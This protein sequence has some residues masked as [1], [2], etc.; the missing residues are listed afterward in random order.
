MALDN[1]VTEGC[2]SNFKMNIAIN[3]Y[4]D[5]RIHLIFLCGRKSF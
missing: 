2:F 4:L 5:C 3:F 1:S